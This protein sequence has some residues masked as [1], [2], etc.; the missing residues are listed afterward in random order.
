MAAVLASV[1]EGG[2]AVGGGGRWVA[3]QWV[4]VVD[5]SDGGEKE[6]RG[7]RGERE[8]TMRERERMRRR[9]LMKSLSERLRGKKIWGNFVRG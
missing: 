4:A 1:A 9:E 3:V 5:G 6:R 2:C 7:M 8:I